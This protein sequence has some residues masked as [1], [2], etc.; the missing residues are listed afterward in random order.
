MCP[1][2]VYALDWCKSGVPGGR[3]SAFRLAA[4]SLTEDF[5]N[6]IAVLGLRDERVLIEDDA[7]PAAP[8]ELATLAEA[9]HGYP[10]TSVQ[11]QPASAAGQGYA[12]K[13][14]PAELLASTGDM[15]R[16]WSFSTDGGAGSGY[17]G[18]APSGQSYSLTA[19]HTL[20]GV[21]PPPRHLPHLLI[22]HSPRRRTG[23]A[24]RSPRSR[25]TRRARR[26]S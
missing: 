3:H 18:R 24:R 20:S 15:L 12:G 7:D 10:A 21:R 11:W 5:R 26:E 6:T 2:P 13:G 23:S 17:V 8:A 14:H 16:V 9:A 22:G 1:G 19:K 4:G 25:G